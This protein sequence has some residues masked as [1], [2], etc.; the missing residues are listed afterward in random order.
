MSQGVYA[1]SPRVSFKAFDMVPHNILVAKLERYGFGG[2][3]ILWIRKWLNG[4]MQ[5][6]AVNSCIRAVTSDV[7][8]RSV[9][10]PVLFNIFINDIDS[11]IECTL[12]KFVD[13]TKLRGAA[14]LLEGRDAIQRDLDRLE[15]W[16]HVNLV[17]FNKAKCKIL[18]MG[19]GSYQYQRRLGDE[20]IE[21]SPEEKDLRISV[22]EKLDITWQR[23][24]AAQKANG[25]LD[26]IK[27]SVAIR[28]REVFS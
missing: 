1:K 23:V 10:R 26:C 17:K 4:H 25:T 7:H 3:T 27:R 12:S 15:R 6:V 24:L 21:S 18:H 28:S 2:W 9:L 8:Q 5:R 13:D 16:A 11:G 19:R 22:A 14:V 20:W